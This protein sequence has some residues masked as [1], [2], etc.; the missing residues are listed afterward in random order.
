MLSVAKLSVRNLDYYIELAQDNYY[1][2]SS[3]EAGRWW[4]RGAEELELDELVR[5]EVLRNVFRG[6]SPD[7]SQAL[8]QNAGR[9]DGPRARRAGFDLTF[10]APKDLSILFAA[11][12]SEQERARLIA[13]HERGVDLALEQLEKLACKT[14][15]GKAGKQVEDARGFTFARFRHEASRENDP[16]LHTHCLL[17]N[18]VRSHDGTWRSFDAR[19]LLRAGLKKQL[20][21]LY[22]QAVGDMLRDELG[23]QVSFYGESYVRV[24]AVP[25]ELRERYSK[26]RAQILEIGYDSAAQAAQVALRTRQV[27][28][29]SQS[30]EQLAQRWREELAAEL[31]EDF[32]LEKLGRE[33]SAEEGPALERDAA[34]PGPDSAPKAP[35]QR[36]PFQAAR[37]AFHRTF[38]ERSSRVITWLET[39]RRK[40]SRFERDR[41][42]LLALS[43][44]EKRLGSLSKAELEALASIHK[45]SGMQMLV[46]TRNKAA[47]EALSRSGTNAMSAWGLHRI[48]T[49]PVTE[50]LR[51]NL[52]RKG[53]ARS[54]RG[55]RLWKLS[56]RSLR[57]L[58][59]GFRPQDRPLMSSLLTRKT[60]L[61]IDRRALSSKQLMLIRERAAAAGSRVLMTASIPEGAELSLSG[62]LKPSR[63]PAV[64]RDQGRRRERR[65]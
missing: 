27:K 65:L 25:Q 28:D 36:K 49:A 11:T 8:V 21:A 41:V 39:S 3:S 19:H 30:P 29:E 61:V 55:Y 54:L 22:R 33:R 51:Y 9:L 38:P 59:R 31:G 17:A 24:H 26:R 44:G 10:S 52:S 40:L 62:F 57:R 6:F 5:P 35:Q 4:G 53:I 18:T 23:L 20:G 45:K 42:R 34:K 50:R 58:L 63:G 48:L 32:T 15:S 1:E 37:A 43:T 47:A 14:R 60:V 46:L 2:R 12:T 13:I 64:E 56:S 7:G 16:Q